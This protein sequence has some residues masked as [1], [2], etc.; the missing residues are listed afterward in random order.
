MP[1]ITHIG[2]IAV[3]VILMTVVGMLLI[4][5]RTYLNGK[6]SKYT[7]LCDACEQPIELTTKPI[8]VLQLCPQCRERWRSLR[9]KGSIK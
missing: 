9:N 1:I 6:N 3:I 4:W 8:E 5:F 2:I 7:I